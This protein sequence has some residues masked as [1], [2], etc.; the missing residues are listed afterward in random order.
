MVG[1]EAMDYFALDA[2][3]QLDMQWLFGTAQAE[4]YA[5]L[6]RDWR[7]R[8]PIRDRESRRWFFW[9]HNVLNLPPPMC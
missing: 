9:N 2:D 7:H 8:D 6:E 3:R 4:H 1:V 5:L